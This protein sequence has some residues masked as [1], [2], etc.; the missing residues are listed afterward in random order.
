MDNVQYTWIIVRTGQSVYAGQ[1]GIWVS[2]SVCSGWTQKVH[3]NWQNTT[4]IFL[5]SDSESSSSGALNPSLTPPS[6]VETL[7]DDFCGML[8]GM[9]A[10]DS[11]DMSVTSSV[12]CSTVAIALEVAWV[13]LCCIDLP[14]S[15]QIHVNGYLVWTTYLVGLALHNNT[16]TYFLHWDASVSA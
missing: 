16:A 15:A 7:L 5:L 10:P 8:G 4:I 3:V 2:A 9:G 14:W 12:S 1:S 13:L 6:T 11:F